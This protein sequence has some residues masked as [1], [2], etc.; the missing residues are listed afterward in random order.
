[1]KCSK[2]KAE[3]MPGNVKSQLFTCPFCGAP[4]GS[5]TAVDENLTM[6]DVIV[7]IVEH[8][9]EEILSQESKCMAAFKDFAPKMEKEQKILKIAFS[10]GI[11]NYFLR[12]PVA[13]RESHLQKARQSMNVLLSDEASLLVVNS[14]AIALGW[15][16]N[17]PEQKIAKV[18]DGMTGTEHSASA[19]E[20]GESIVVVGI[21]GCGSNTIDRMIS[22]GQKGIKFITIDT[23][24]QALMKS[25]APERIQI[26]EKLTR[27]RGSGGIPKIGKAAAEA[28]C[29]N[30]ADALKGA[31]IVFI[32]VGMGGGTGTGAAPIVAACARATGAL[33]IVLVNTPFTF[34]G[35]RFIQNSKTGI[36]ELSRESDTIVKVS[37][38]TLLSVVGRNTPMMDTF[39]ICDDYFGQ[40]IRG[41]SDLMYRPKLINIDLKHIMKKAGPVLIGIGEGSG[42]N[43]L[44]KAAENALKCPF[45]EMPIHGARNVILFIIC[46][47]KSLPLNDINEV[48][49]I[50]MKTAGDGANIIYGSAVDNTMKD[51]TIRMMFIATGVESSKQ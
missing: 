4:L 27:G 41:I 40:I 11:S 6:S 12:C 5:A 2:C 13:D 15:N 31:T 38:D 50:F 43:A 9:G 48:V 39:R 47:D 37:N 30:L 35:K 19:I 26:G 21:G 49:E 1:M 8:F 33:S 25:L 36:S 32:L 18:F 23:D 46:S 29:S 14:F 51:D 17:R 28:C 42:E 7:Q 10:E 20:N 16:I 45:L 34:E 3:W 44:T 24:A 22:S